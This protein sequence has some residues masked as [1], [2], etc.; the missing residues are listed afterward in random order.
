MLEHRLSKQRFLSG[1]KFT[2]LDLR[3][4]MTLVRFDPVYT[5]YFKTNLK[6]IADY[7]NL[8]GYVRDIYSYG[9]NQE[10]NQYETHKDP[11]LHKPSSPQHVRNRS[12]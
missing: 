2:W 1:D 12:N 6:R 4:F 10:V 3:L 9:A 8:L 11:L 7:P 5:T